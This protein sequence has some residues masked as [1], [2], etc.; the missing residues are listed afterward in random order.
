MLEYL[1][2]IREAFVRAPLRILQAPAGGV[3]V[4]SYAFVWC[5]LL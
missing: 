5:R 4:S 3:F 2:F 1:M